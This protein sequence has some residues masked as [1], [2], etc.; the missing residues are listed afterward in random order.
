MRVLLHNGQPWILVSRTSREVELYRRSA[1]T[2]SLVP[3]PALMSGD[4]L[5]GWVLD[6]ALDAEGNLVLLVDWGNQMLYQRPGGFEQIT[7]PR[8][9][10]SA[11]FGGGLMVDGR[12]RVHVTYVYDEIGGNSDG[13]GGVVIS[14]R[15][16]YGV[17]EATTWT[18]YELG[19]VAYPRIVT[20]DGG[21]MRVV[22]GL[23]KGRQTPLA[24]TE[25]ASDG[26]LRSELITLDP[27]P[28]FGTSPD[29]FV[30][31]TAAAGP[32]GTIAAAWD[33][34]RVYIRPPDVHGEAGGA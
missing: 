21:P 20:R 22:H 11:G 19:P 18:S 33:G 1:D 13:T 17:Y 32:D 31:P 3:L 34:Q 24:L 9:G 27:S 5:A 23:Y 4:P 7:L 29:P 30:H 10:P 25:V 15:G 26:S 28:A 8:N 6:G 16:I 2:W 14:G 12:G